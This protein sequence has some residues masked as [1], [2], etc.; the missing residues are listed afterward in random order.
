MFSKECN[1]LTKAAYSDDLEEMILAFNFVN[2]KDFSISDYPLMS[3]PWNELPTYD[4]PMGA[5]HVACD[6]GNLEIVRFLI[7]C[8]CCLNIKDINGH[9]PLEVC[10][11][12][13]SISV[14]E[15]EQRRYLDIF[16]LLLNSGSSF[17]ILDLRDFSI[18]C[19]QHPVTYAFYDDSILLIECCYP[20]LNVDVLRDQLCWFIEQFPESLNVIRWVAR[21][22][23][24]DDCK[25]LKFF[26]I[27]IRECEFHFLNDLEFLDFFIF[28][29]F[30]TPP[31]LLFDTYF[32]GNAQL[33]TSRLMQLDDSF[34]NVF[35]FVEL[36]WFHDTSRKVN[37]HRVNAYGHRTFNKNFYRLFL[38]KIPFLILLKKVLWKREERRLTD[39]PKDVS[40]LIVHFIGCVDISSLSFLRS[41]MKFKKFEMS[42]LS[43]FTKIFLLFEE[44][45][46]MSNVLLSSSKRIDYK[47]RL[48]S[49]VDNDYED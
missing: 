40:S 38:S 6:R 5:I 35:R 23:F 21:M 7:E 43:R 48:R 14:D 37:V 41:F 20:F 33:C 2:G 34:E 1:F 45:K 4:Y 22:I 28:G 39:L 31:Q 29:V 8:G 10:L 36:G 17:N 44:V 46:K 13:Y 24:E 27:L 18:D 32:K 11:Q 16:S 12:G 30:D 42:V 9:T 15:Q 25:K 19:D 26:S 3:D 49:Y 47:K